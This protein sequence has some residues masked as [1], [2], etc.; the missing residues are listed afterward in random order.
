MRSIILATVLLGGCVSQA[1][2]DAIH[3]AHAPDLARLH[4]AAEE[5]KASY[6]ALPP[7]VRKVLCVPGVLPPDAEAA[8][9][10]YCAVSVHVWTSLCEPGT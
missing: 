4:V 7:A 2:I 3:E 1:T 6:C 8:E 5:A 10:I 9:L